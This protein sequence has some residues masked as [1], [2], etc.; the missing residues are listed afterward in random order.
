MTVNRP[1]LRYHGAKFRL[2]TWIL[3]Y[4]P[5]HKVYVEPF[6]GAAGVLL[7]KPRSYSEVYNDLDKYIVNLFKV[8]RDPVLCEQLKIA[9]KLTPYSR[10]EF[11]NALQVSSEPVE[12]ARRTLIRSCMGFGSAGCNYNTGFRI[13]VRRQYTTA[14][15]L[16]VNQPECL[17]AI[18]SRLQGVLIENRPAIKVLQQFDD[19]DTLHYIDPPYLKSVRCGRNYYRHEMTDE[20]HIE[21]L[22]LCNSL[23]GHVVIS[24]YDSE[25]YNK[26]LDGWHKEKTNSRISA[27]RGT[28]IREECLW[29]NFQPEVFTGN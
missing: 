1:L 14:P 20:D 22:T 4:F 24:G 2:A 28:G 16:W 6:A 25:L 8:V 7:R 3:K 17:D 19:T 18:C 29:M 26:Q 21:L 23:K 11:E 9:C 10:Y 5:E 12:Q 27:G 13:D 15:K